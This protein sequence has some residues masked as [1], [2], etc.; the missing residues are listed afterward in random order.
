MTLKSHNNLKL[1]WDISDSPHFLKEYFKEILVSMKHQKTMN[2]F[3]FRIID[4]EN[5]TNDHLKQLGQILE[6]RNDLKRVYLNFEGCKNIGD[7]GL[8]SFIKSLCKNPK[9][10]IDE[11]HLNVIQSAVKEEEF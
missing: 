7:E 6:K 10:C 4:N 5:F 8:N 9:F 1:A 2:T 11:L 3:D